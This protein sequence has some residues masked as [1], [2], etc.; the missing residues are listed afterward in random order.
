MQDVQFYRDSDLPFFE[1]KLC[2]SE[3]LAYKKHAH[4]EYSLGV[5]QQGKSSFWYGGKTADV[6]P[7]TIVLVPPGAVHSCNPE[8]GVAWQYKMLFVEAGWVRNFFA[9]AGIADCE[10]P[11]VWAMPRL[12]TVA[13]NRLV[14]SLARPLTPLA[15]ETHIMALFEQTMADKSRM[16]QKSPVKQIANCKMIKEYLQENFLSKITLDDL[17]QV[18]GIGK[19]NILRSFKEQFSIPPHTYQTLLRINYAKKQLRQN[20]D[21]PD[22]ACEA[23]FYDQSHF[24]KVFKSHTGATPEKYQKLK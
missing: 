10:Q 9:G 17:E 4:E 20:R 11:L 18:S 5:I 24:N 14:D 2:N 3:R 23:G 15:K 7:R 8:P 1:L 21:I 16:V 12:Q 19:Y 6:C 22:V 13:M